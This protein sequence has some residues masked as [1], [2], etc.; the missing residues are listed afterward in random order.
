MSYPLGNKEGVRVV[1]DMS[2]FEFDSE[3]PQFRSR[4]PTPPSGMAYNLPKPAINDYTDTLNIPNN[5]AMDPPRVVTHTAQQLEEVLLDDGP[6]PPAKDSSYKRLSSMY[7][8]NMNR[9]ASN[10]T[11]SHTPQTILQP[12]SHPTPHQVHEVEATTP[13]KQVHLRPPSSYYPMSRRYSI[14]SSYPQN[15]T[16]LG[17]YPP[18]SQLYLPAYEQAQYQ[19]A[20]LQNQTLGPDDLPPMAQPG[21]LVEIPNG[22]GRRRFLPETVFQ[23][24]PKKNFLRHMLL[25]QVM[26]KPVY[27]FPEKDFD[28]NVFI[29]TTHISYHFFLYFFEAVFE[30]IIIILSSFLLSIDNQIDSGIYRYFVGSSVVEVVIALAFLTT[31][32]DFE[33]RNGNFYCIIATVLCSIS[34]IMTCSQI[35]SKP[36]C[37]SS[38]IC[39]MR[40]ALLSF[41]IMSTFLW[42]IT[43]TMY[44]TT[45]YVAKLDALEEVTFHTQPAQGYN[46]LPPQTTPSEYAA[47][48]GRSPLN[49]QHAPPTQVDDLAPPVR[50]TPDVNTAANTTAT[51][52]IDPETGRPL[53]LFYLSDQGEMFELA[54]AAGLENYN[55]ILVYTFG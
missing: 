39:G 30:I 25:Q 21:D 29:N 2:R 14:N 16:S 17:H 41:V 40:K 11:R 34:F 22:G 44:L 9:S 24:N 33:N 20:Q 1:S 27:H 52:I 32:I 3:T 48:T 45:I 43:L 31:L 7:S 55:K 37:S 35:L 42:V 19:A 13:E 23:R 54:S 51:P 49:A 12:S 46:E 4:N 15:Q 8:Q 36:N 47:S 10:N 53:R 38:N 6:S 28:T 5:T 50:A 18:P 26:N